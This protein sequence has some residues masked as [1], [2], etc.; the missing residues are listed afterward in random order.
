LEANFFSGT[1]GTTTPLPPDRRHRNGL[2]NVFFP[3]SKEL[4]YFFA[5]L[6][7][8]ILGSSLHDPKPPV[9]P[10]RFR[11]R[12]I[13]DFPCI[14]WSVFFFFFWRFRSGRFPGGSACLVDFLFTGRTSSPPFFF[15]SLREEAES[16]A[17]KIV[18]GL[19]PS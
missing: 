13:A 10:K 16:A 8:L 17:F 11:P 14:S 3:S 2:Q 19:F 18:Q 15:S 12:P 5:P 7:R 6:G 4:D 1:S 9:G